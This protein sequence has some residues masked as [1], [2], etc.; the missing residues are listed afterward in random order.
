M[1]LAVTGVSTVACIPAAGVES[2]AAL[3]SVDA[4]VYVAVSSLHKVPTIA[5]VP[6]LLECSLSLLLIA[7]LLLMDPCLGSPL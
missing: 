4:N 3:D 6:G 5:S 1:Q 7:S 2:A